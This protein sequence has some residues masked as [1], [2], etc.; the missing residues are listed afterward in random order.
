MIER[1]PPDFSDVISLQKIKSRNFTYDR[2][3]SD[4]LCLEWSGEGTTCEEA[5]LMFNQMEALPHW[6]LQH[7]HV[8]GYKGESIPS[9]LRRHLLP[10]LGSL[11]FHSCCNIK[12][13]LF[14]VNATGSDN[15]NSIKEL[16][17][18][19]CDQI[20]WEGSMV[21]PTSL[22]KLILSKSVSR[23]LAPKAGGPRVLSS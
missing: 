5:E 9:C 10:R 3:Q 23:A 14:F 17:I 8:R 21:P 20:N 22:R 18:W 16:V 4:K 1:F 2:D 13:I 12:S 11:E 19:S 6:N 7:L 15:H